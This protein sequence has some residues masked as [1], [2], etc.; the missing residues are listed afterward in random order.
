MRD[1]QLYA[2]I[3]GIDR[4]WKVMDVEL[5]L[6]HD[7]V[8]VRIPGAARGRCIAPSAARRARVTTSGSGGGG[9]LIRAS[10]GR[11]WWRRCHG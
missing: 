1:T 6:P 4:P 8:R 3:L 10:T 5:D 9:T 11:S 2:R 7:E